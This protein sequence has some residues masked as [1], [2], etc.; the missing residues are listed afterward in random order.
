[1]KSVHEMAVR[2]VELQ[3]FQRHWSRWR[4]TFTSPVCV[5]EGHLPL[6]RWWE[7]CSSRG[8]VNECTT[9]PQSCTMWGSRCYTSQ[10]PRH[11]CQRG[12]YCHALLQGNI[13]FYII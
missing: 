12:A 11:C 7:T 13:V 3:W 1:M 4:Q 5:E 9:S 6:T 2:N 10:W 8:G